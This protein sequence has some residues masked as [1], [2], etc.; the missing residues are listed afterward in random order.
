MNSTL[1]VIERHCSLCVNL[2]VGERFN[3]GKFNVEIFVECDVILECNARVPRVSVVFPTSKEIAQAF[4]F[5]PAL[6]MV[7][8][9]FNI[10]PI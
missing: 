3:V 1:T 7:T 8:D 2:T 4:Y 5:N 10:K 9:W 6:G